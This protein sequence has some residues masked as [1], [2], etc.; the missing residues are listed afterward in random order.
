MRAGGL[1]GI[2]APYALVGH[3]GEVVTIENDDLTSLQ[4]GFD[5]SLDV[6]AAVLVEELQFL[7]GG[8]TAGSGGFTEPAPK[9]A[10]GRFARERDAVALLAESGS[11]EFRLGGFPGAVDAFED[12]ERARVGTGHGVGRRS[13]VRG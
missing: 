8:K 4:G 10:I 3:G 9:G 11:E 12:N 5:E 6:L 7:L 13:K 2:E 1:L